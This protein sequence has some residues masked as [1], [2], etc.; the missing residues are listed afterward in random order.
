M[1]SFS[2]HGLQYIKLFCLGVHSLQ[3]DRGDVLGVVLAEPWR[4]AG[5]GGPG[6]D[7]GAD[8]DH[9]DGQRQ[10]GPAQDLLHEVD[11]HLPGRVLLHGVR[12]ADRV[13]MRGIHGQTDPTQVRKEESRD[14]HM[15][16]SFVFDKQ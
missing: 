4:G 13:R 16:G 6:R 1:Y 7:N 10:R 3:P 11:R 2:D 14:V 5:P 8:H 9:A 15:K 12:G